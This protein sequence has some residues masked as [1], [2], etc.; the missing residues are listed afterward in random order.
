MLIRLGNQK[1]LTE[2][3]GEENVPKFLHISEIYIGSSIESK[4]EELF[5]GLDAFD[6]SLL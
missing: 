2:V 6:L 3:M 5:K 1:N 4:H